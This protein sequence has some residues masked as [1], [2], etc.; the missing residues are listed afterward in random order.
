MALGSGD[1][2]N[3]AAL[4]FF[5]FS[6]LSCRLFHS[7]TWCVTVSVF[8]TRLPAIFTFVFLKSS[9]AQCWVQPP[10]TKDTPARPTL[11]SPLPHVPHRVQ[12]RDD[13]VRTGAPL[14]TECEDKW[15]T[16]RYWCPDLIDSFSLVQNSL[17]YS[18]SGMEKLKVTFVEGTGATY[19]VKEKRETL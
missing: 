19:C 3:A 11:S 4:T 13:V 15:Y 17:Q 6:S 10:T 2:Q 7:L 8:A 18:A 14:P 12:R 5:F 1:S 16:L 9:L